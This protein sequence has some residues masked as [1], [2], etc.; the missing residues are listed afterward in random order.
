M[1]LNQ[2]PPPQDMADAIRKDQQNQNR[3]IELDPSQ[4]KDASK[5]KTPISATQN[6]PTNTRS[7]GRKHKTESPISQVRNVKKLNHI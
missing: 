5:T 6:I 7:V 1:C 4:D 2:V 3:S